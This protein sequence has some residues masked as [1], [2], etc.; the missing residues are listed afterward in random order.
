MLQSLFNYARRNYNSGV[1][2]AQRA[3]LSSDLVPAG[4]TAGYTLQRNS[5]NVLKSSLVGL[6]VGVSEAVSEFESPSFATSNLG[7]MLNVVKH[8]IALPF[9]NIE[10]IIPEAKPTVARILADGMA[11]ASDTLE[12]LQKMGLTSLARWAHF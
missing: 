2:E 11:L 8:L 1:E 7:D 12:A 4:H 6:N 3:L 9:D 10:A 5:T